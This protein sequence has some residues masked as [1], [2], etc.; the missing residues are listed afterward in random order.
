[1]SQ[2]IIKVEN[3][4]KKYCR[5]LKRSL[6]YGV[7]DTW[8]EILGRDGKYRKT[9]REKE[10]WALEDINFEVRKGECLGLIGRNGAGKS[11][12]LKILN[13][14]I[15]PDRG[16]VKIKGRVGALIELGAGFNP[17]LTGRENVYING[18][19]L[20]FS[21]RDV[22]QV[23]DEIVAFA[24]L[25]DFIDSPVQYYSSGMKVRLGFA[26]ASQMKPDVLLIDEVLAVGDAGFRA[27][28]YNEIFKILPNA[29]VIF[30][31][32]SM[33]QVSKICT[34]GILLSKGKINS[35]S[36]NVSQVISSYF[37]LFLSDSL[38]FEGTNKT[39]LQKLEI[40]SQSDSWIIDLEKQ[41]NI[42]A[43]ISVGPK[44]PVSFL[45]H[46][47]AAERIDQA[48]ILIAFFDGESNLVAQFEP[49]QLFSFKKDSKKIIQLKTEQLVLGMGNFTMSLHVIQK[50]KNSE[51]G[52]NL[53]GVRNLI[54][55]SLRHKLIF[56]SAP[57]QIQAK[58]HEI[59]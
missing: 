14:L 26:I 9:L 4:S 25:E 21:K 6:I 7:G 45:C 49:S 15:K 44:A 38:R 36:P 13:G 55:L 27:K 8:N 47:F 5:D 34:R 23:F 33:S 22:G 46:F 19:V 54:N 52:E 35:T 59:N 50:D 30:V 17:I 56:G 24:E 58:W 28:C 32:H 20:G 40:F 3:L 41:E 2:P 16:T 11:T 10:F 51:W 48:R 43:K 53:F 31:S 18:A 57:I 42:G 1:M 37:D 29:A 12:L 39:K